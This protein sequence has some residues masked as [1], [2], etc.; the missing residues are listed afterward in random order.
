MVARNLCGVRLSLTSTL[1]LL[2]ESL[3]WTRR[4]LAR[5]RFWDRAVSTWPQ[6]TWTPASWTANTLTSKSKEISSRE[7]TSRSCTKATP[8]TTWTTPTTIPITTLWPICS[9]V[10]S[11]TSPNQESEATT[12][13]TPTITWMPAGEWTISLNIRIKTKIHHKSTIKLNQSHR[14]SM[15]EALPIR[16]TFPT[17][18]FLSL[19]CLTSITPQLTQP[20]AHHQ[21]SP[22]SRQPECQPWSRCQPLRSQQCQLWPSHQRLCTPPHRFHPEL[23]PPRLLP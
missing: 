16:A 9:Q 17:R 4:Q 3:S 22:Q 15:L 13:W 5:I 21:E 20:L 18:I 7:S 23:W 8:W 11:T 1:I 14:Q 6:P 10:I 12:T 19:A 2:S